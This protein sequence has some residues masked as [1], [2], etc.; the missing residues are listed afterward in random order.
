MGISL[1]T[2]AAARRR[3]LWAAGL[4]VAL[5]AGVA[6]TTPAAAATPESATLISTAATT[7]KY[8]DNNTEPCPTTD[9]NAWTGTGFDDSAWKSGTGGFG[10]KRG[11][12]SIAGGTINT[13]LNQYIDP[14]AASKVDVP[15]FF[16]R[17]SFELSA[18]QL[19]ELATLTGSV[20]YD[21]AIRIYVNG[22]KV[23]NFF[24][25]RATSTSTNLQY[26][27]VS[28]G[29]PVTSDFTVPSSAVHAGTNTV[30]VALY[31]DRE[32]SSDI[33]FDLSGLVA[34]FTDPVAVPQLSAVSLNIGSDPSQRNL[35]WYSSMDMAQAVQVAPAA[36]MSGDTFPSAQATTFAGSGGAATA[37]GSYWRHATITDLTPSTEYVY[38][39]GNDAAWSPTYRMT[40]PA[41]DHDITFVAVGD[42]QE[43]ASGNVTNDQAGWQ[44]TVDRA[45][46]TSPDTDFIMSLGDQVNTASNEDQYR[47]FLAPAQLTGIPMA[48]TIGNHDVSSLAYSQ[49]FNMPNVDPS[50]GAAGNATS[51]GGDY[52]FRYGDALVMDLNSNNTDNASHADFVTST[53]AAHPEAQWKIVVFHHSIYSTASHADDGDIVARRAALPTILSTAGV[54][55][56]LMG[57]DHVYA[58]T[59]LIKNGAIDEDTTGGA[60]ASV[61][62]KPGDVLYVT[63]NSASGSKYYSISGTHDWAAVTNQDQLPSYTAVKV[64]PSAIT[65]TTV[66]TADGSTIDTVALH[67]ADVTKPQLTLPSDNQIGVDSSFDPMAGVTATDDTDGDLTSAVTVSGQVNTS[68]P[69]SYELTYSV[70][71]A[72]GNTTTATRTITVVSGVLTS[73]GVPRISGMVKVGSVVTAVTP[74]WQPTPS[75]S[76]QWLLNGKALPGK[77][78]ARLPV[79]PSYALGRLSVRVTGTRAGYES[80]TQTSVPVTVAKGDFSRVSKPKIKGK[81]RVGARLTVN[82]G[83]WSPAP[84]FAFRWYANGKAI[85]GATGTRL[86]LTRK[87]KGKRISVKVVATKTGYKTRSYTSARTAKV[88][89]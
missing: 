69:G 86:K 39:V 17:S 42:V 82:T 23:A 55:L 19:S 83:K 34:S 28:N 74:A 49:H 6:A 76:F 26:A 33:Y 81:A 43:G 10:A 36:A 61:A 77:T 62:A 78:S 14:A 13:L 58:R 29:D 59:W 85:K 79:A 52:W 15:T 63:G 56:V 7:W 11:T 46:T 38:R 60:K 40:T 4:A 37:S 66:H 45:L 64:T 32:E 54:D 12:S 72:A 53:I 27:G 8:L 47:A 41:D 51:A 22:T 35:A 44:A 67:K 80:L 73:T 50:H 57:H 68:V 48:T 30:A 3:R 87:L 88:K 16:F 9:L 2:P 75:Y 70:T 71:D 20:S 21:D 89:R 18:S 5:L 65:L 31:Q 1:A 25:D 84:A 24:D